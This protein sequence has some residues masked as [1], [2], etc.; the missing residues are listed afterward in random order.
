MCVK[1]ILSVLFDLKEGV[2]LAYVSWNYAVFHRVTFHFN[3]H[4]KRNEFF[5]YSLIQK[6]FN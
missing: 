2:S 4:L 5:S 3:F 6:Y 1:W